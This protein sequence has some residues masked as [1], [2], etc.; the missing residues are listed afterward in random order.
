MEWLRRLSDAGIT[1]SRMVPEN[2]GLARIPG[3][4]S[5]LV[6]NEQIMFNDGAD[7]EFVIQGVKPSDALAMAGALNET[8]RQ[9]P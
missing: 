9:T 8:W 3:T 4:L 2:Y 5:L 6:D 7:N 1:A